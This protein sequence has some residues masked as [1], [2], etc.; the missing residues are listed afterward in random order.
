MKEERSTIVSPETSLDSNSILEVAD[1]AKHFAIKR[2][3]AG[4]LRR[5]PE[6]AVRAIDGVSFEL[7]RGE[8]LALVGESGCGK[9]TTALSVL[10]L[11]EPSGGTVRF[12]GRPLHE[13]L[14]RDRSLRQAIQMVFQDPYES[15]N[16]RMTVTELVA[17]PLEVHHLFANQEEKRRKVITA[18]EE[19]GLRPANE[20]VNRLPHELSGGQRQRVVIAAALVTG[21]RLLVADEPVSML[22]VSIRAEILL[23]LNELRRRHQISI[24][25]ITHDLATAALFADRIAVMYLGRIV[26]IGP[27][28]AVLE[29]PLH[30]Y[31]KALLSVIP[32]PDPRHKRKRV[33][34][35][36]ETPNPAD[37]PPGCRFH[38]RCPLAVEACRATDPRL[39]LKQGHEVACI[40]V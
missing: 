36:G 5:A 15:L 37:I 6:R 40:R 16:P 12:E 3:L 10:G 21:P 8:V 27:A 19:V 20:F 17:E 14:R 29:N 31:T 23:L 11:V 35:Q 24:L 33:I 9:T 4:A 32:N 25:F 13:T 30:P 26:E 38:P 18:L 34:L 1:L 28:S 7:R 22:D 39:E 2:G